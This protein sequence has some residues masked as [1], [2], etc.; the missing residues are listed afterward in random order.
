MAYLFDDSK[1]KVD[2]DAVLQPKFTTLENSYRA[3]IATIANAITDQG[4]TTSTTASPATMATNIA[5]I[6]AQQYTVDIIDSWG[7]GHTSYQCDIWMADT[8]TLTNASLSNVSITVRF[9][10]ATDGW[11]QRT[12]SQEASITFA[13]AP[14]VIKG[15]TVTVDLSNQNSA[16]RV[17]MYGHVGKMIGH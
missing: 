9:L 10:D 3:N 8:V 13:V 1:K 2:V 11:L 15:N 17:L 14:D 12:L 5:A 6:L 7:Y 4:I 16:V